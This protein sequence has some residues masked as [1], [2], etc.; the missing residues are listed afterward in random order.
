MSNILE[1]NREIA[2]PRPLELPSYKKE[3]PIFNIDCLLK[4]IAD[5]VSD[6]ANSIQQ[7]N[8]IYSYI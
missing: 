6:L 1:L 2:E 3:L 5:Y 4:V 8:K 7:A